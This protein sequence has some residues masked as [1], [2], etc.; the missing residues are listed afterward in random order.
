[1]PE[2]F[3]FR[4]TSLLLLFTIWNGW[5][6]R[7]SWNGTVHTQVL[8]RSGMPSSKIGYLFCLIFQDWRAWKASIFFLFQ[9]IKTS[10]R[11]VPVLFTSANNFPQIM[12]P[13]LF[14]K[15]H[16]KWKQKRTHIFIKKIKK[17][18]DNSPWSGIELG[19]PTS[20]ANV[21]TTTLKGHTIYLF[22]LTRT[23]HCFRNRWLCNWRDMVIHGH[24]LFFVQ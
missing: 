12:L 22:G 16:R 7:Y 13:K 17:M 14:R 1:M 10:C 9:S 18:A 11:W 3:F 2:F 5:C 21:L 8:Q 23:L 20:K 15:F 24:G 6:G 4:E 19:S